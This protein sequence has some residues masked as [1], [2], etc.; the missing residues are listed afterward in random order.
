MAT[1][2]RARFEPCGAEAWRDPFPMYQRLRERDPVHH[3]EDNG[4][5]ED[6]WVLSR[7]EHVLEAAVD[8]RTISSAQ[9]LTFA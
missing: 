7:F 1:S 8:A 4:E 5:G 9:G 3:V 2:P 6:Y